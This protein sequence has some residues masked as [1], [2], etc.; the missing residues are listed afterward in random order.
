MVLCKL[1]L[2]LCLPE[3]PCTCPDELVVEVALV[4]GAVPASS[5]NGAQR[6]LAQINALE[7]LGSG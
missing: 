3:D 1:A 7:A 2:W 4:I 5:V 6:C